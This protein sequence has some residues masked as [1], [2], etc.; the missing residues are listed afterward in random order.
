MNQDCETVSVR[1]FGNDTD[2]ASVKSYPYAP[3]QVRR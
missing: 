3:G 1:R 2:C